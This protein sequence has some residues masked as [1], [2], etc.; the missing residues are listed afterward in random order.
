L[1][2]ADVDLGRS[3]VSRTGSLGEHLRKT[4]PEVKAW[5]K[6]HGCDSVYGTDLGTGDEWAVPNDPGQI[7]N[8]C[9]SG[10][11]GSTTIM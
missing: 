3:V 8:I 10:Y 5:L 4:L 1:L 6:S 7:T 9:V 11:H 2:S